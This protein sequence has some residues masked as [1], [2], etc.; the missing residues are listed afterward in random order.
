MSQRTRYLSKVYQRRSSPVTVS[1]DRLEGGETDRIQ[2]VL[3]AKGKSR[4]TLFAGV[5]VIC[6]QICGNI[7]ANRRGAA[8]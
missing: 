4:V 8:D 1:F 3:Q 7:I 5:E 2:V 6:R